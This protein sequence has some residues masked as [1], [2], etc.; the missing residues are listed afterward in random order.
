MS[1]E[2]KTLRAFLATVREGS[3]SRAAESLG[4][5][6][7]TVS[8]QLRK[9]ELALGFGLLRRTTRRIELTA[10]GK[11][12]LP[13]VDT[14]LKHE[15]RLKRSIDDI[16]G[17]M[18][19]TMTLGSAVYQQQLPERVAL[20]DAFTAAHPELQ[21]EIDNRLQM[22]HVN[23]LL[24]GELDAAFLVGCPVARR[25]G[26]WDRELLFP[27]HLP[28]LVLK[29]RPVDLMLPANSPLTR[30]KVVPAT[31][32]SGQSVLMLGPVHGA[33]LVEPVM[34]FL[35]SA[36]ATVVIPAEST[37]LAL[38]RHV[39]QSAK[40]AMSTGWFRAP[41][42]QRGELVRRPIEGLTVETELALVFR[43]G[44]RARPA[45]ALHAFVRKH[46]AR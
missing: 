4:V 45:R 41:G 37:E 12:L 39:R 14:L 22:D 30:F 40:L 7:P 33:E 18:R 9:L 38:A 3:V 6:Q 46:V 13:L 21:I 43:K 5:R 25:G 15:E 35:K 23:A 29:R 34:R 26:A 27:A 20:L 31:A 2:A 10:E 8:A 1:F 19:S 36:G 17:R 24:R 42:E 28:R 32:L 44:E 16:R 11:R